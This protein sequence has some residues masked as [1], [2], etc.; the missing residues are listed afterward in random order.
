MINRLCA[1]A[2][3]G[4]S[5]WIDFI[6]RE[7]LSSGQLAKMVAEDGVV[8]LTSNPSIFEKA[9]SSGQSYDAGIAVGAQAGL[10]VEEIYE[11]LALDDIIAAA[12]LLLPVY[13]RSG[14]LD[15]Y[16]SLEVAP[17]LANDA[18]GTAYHARRLHAALG[19]PNVMIKVP[20][21]PAG[22]PAIRELIGSGISVNATLL[23]GI[24]AYDAAAHAYLDGLETW[25]AAGGDPAR[26]AS[27]ASFFVSRVDTA[28]DK[29]L[30]SPEAGRW[31]G[32][33]AVANARLAYARFEEIFSGARWQALAA[34]GA[35][36]QRPLWASTST[37]DPSYSDTIYVDE[38]IGPHTVNTMPPATLAAFRD[39]G[40]P[41]RTI[42]TD[43]TGARATM[44]GLEQHGVNMAAVT[45]ELL[46]AGVRAFSDA[47]DR[48]LSG[49]E[50]KVAGLRRS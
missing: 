49:L 40:H 3:Y 23:F 18:V 2:D 48:L 9:I 14:G 32:K 29:Q 44:V 30:V 7:A 37:K 4:Q 38:L 11:S 19:R 33:A 22:V 27:V 34:R 17:R 6:S 36:V 5:V 15:G 10:S 31:R 47:F 1:L 24:D 8:G 16:V 12:D 20:G 35:R 39:H 50:G 45:Q 21:T 28:V 43:V 25:V 26:V 42:D 46:D 13:E 41:A